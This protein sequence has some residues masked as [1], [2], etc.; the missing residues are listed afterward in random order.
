MSIFTARRILLAL[1]A[2]T[3]AFSGLMAQEKLPEV[4]LEQGHFTRKGKPFIPVGAHWVPAKAGMHWPVQWDPKD[5]EA[6][7]AKMKELGYNLV[8]IDMLW[9]WFE[10]NPGDYNP[11]AFR[12]L[13]FLVSMGHKYQI[14]IHPCLFVG[15]EVGEA[16]WDVPWRH[17]RNPHSNPDMLRF[18]TEHAKALG[19]RY[20]NETCIIAWDLTDEPPFWIVGGQTTDAAAINWTRLVAWGLRQGG[21]KQPIVVGTSGQETGRG[22]FRS[23]NLVQDVDFFSVHPFTIYKQDLFPDPM[24]S[25]RSTYGAAF[26][27]ALSSGAGKPAMIH[28][29]GGSTAQYAPERV[30]LYDRA[31]LYSGFAAGSIGVNLWCYTDAAPA[32]WRQVPY[33]RTPQE[34]AWG[35]VT[36]DRQD[37]PLAKAF[38]A[39]SKVMGQLDL[40]GMKPE[41]DAGVLVPYE[42]AKPHGDFSRLGLAGSN[43]PTYVSVEDGDAMPDQQNAGKGSGENTALM[44]SLLTSFILGRRAGFA[45]DFPREYGNWNT[46]PLI[47]LPA[48]LTSTGATFLSHVH[49]AFYVQAADYVKNGGHLYASVS[50]DAA[51]PNGE[52]LF[53]ARLVDAH[54]VSDITLK[55]VKPLGTLKVGDTLRFQASGGGPSQWGSLLQVAG[56][57]VIAEDQDGHPALVA[58]SFGKG[59]TL[60][61]AYPLETYLGTRPSAFE[62]PS[63]ADGLYQ[64][65]RAW[66]GVKPLFWTNHPSVEATALKGQG[67]GYVVLVNHSAQ[68]Q[69]I[70]LASSLSLKSLRRIGPNGPEVLK[71][72]GSGCELEVDAYDGI[73]IEWN[74]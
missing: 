1:V 45:V 7:F 36:W 63:D 25:E 9:A 48:P 19:Q 31:N 37:K 69:K 22:P 47:L 12:Q 72:A 4:R 35:M 60:L 26:E 2:L 6:D 30:A 67:R 55:I 70:H 66:G 58:H 64:A 13:D 17:G 57:E 20:A 42:W 3:P 38:R 39:F 74:S 21:A 24:L 15:G 16:Y 10:P 23:D 59:K 8:R 54:Q 33:L 49:T 65:I 73:V 32:L 61:C 51:F 41:A 56:G 50:S 28:E 62:K 11:E 14:Y 44:G 53:G 34:T 46:R 5:I 40:T 43:T 18:Q 71:L 68:K 29:M 52:E 27:I